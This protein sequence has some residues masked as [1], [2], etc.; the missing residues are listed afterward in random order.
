MEVNAIY[1]VKPEVIDLNGV[2][3]HKLQAAKIGIAFT[4][5][6]RPGA[7]APGLSQGF[8]D[9]EV[10]HPHFVSHSGF[11]SEL[12]ELCSLSHAI[13]RLVKD[14]EGEPLH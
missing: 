4:R 3:A 10:L 2:P 12:G 11:D 7:L 5:R 13:P 1:L 14:V 8:P 6:G 9:S